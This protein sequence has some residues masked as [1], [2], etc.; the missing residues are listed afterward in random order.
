MSGDVAPVIPGV[1]YCIVDNKTARPFKVVDSLGCER[2]FTNSVAT[3]DPVGCLVIHDNDTKVSPGGI[4][5]VNG[6]LSHIYSP[7]GW[8]EL[9]FTDIE[10]LA[11]VD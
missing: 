4:S 9:N 11:E 7:G 6:L 8:V 1:V 5:L 10:T 3:I 2:S